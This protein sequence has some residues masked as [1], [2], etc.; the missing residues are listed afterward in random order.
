MAGAGSGPSLD[1][2]DRA[3][4]GQLRGPW[5][6]ALRGN[7]ESP[8]L[9]AA[10]SIGIDTRLHARAGLSPGAALAAH[11][12]CCRSA[13]RHVDAGASALV[14][15]SMRSYFLFVREALCARFIEQCG[16]MF[17]S[18]KPSIMISRGPPRESSP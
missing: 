11:E 13:R 4:A 17:F 8:A 15:R 18:P 10:A 6:R 7:G 3:G 14:R 2:R 5:K 12:Q 1:P 16:M 9:L